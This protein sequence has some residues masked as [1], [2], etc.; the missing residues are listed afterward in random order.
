MA[1]PAIRPAT[2]T[3]APALATLIRSI[4][5]EHYAPILGA[6]QVEYM[7]A[8]RADPAAIAA[9]IAGGIAWLIAVDDAGGAQAYASH[10]HADG[11]LAR[12]GDWKLRQLYVAA[13]QRRAGLGRELFE[14]V[15]GAALAAGA[16]CLILAVN[17]GNHLAQE[18]YHRWGFRVRGDAC[19]PIGGGFV[20]DDHILEMP[21]TR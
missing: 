4:W 14:Q 20:M 16:A 11:P 13:A 12:P 18:A 9:E 3:D 8:S 1:L 5:R 17:R 7:L 10:A 15:R 21:L 2:A 19:T 6:A